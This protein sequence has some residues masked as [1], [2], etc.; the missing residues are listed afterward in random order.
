MDDVTLGADAGDTT[1]QGDQDMAR[2]A[3]V[4]KE[5]KTEKAPR[6]ATDTRKA[7]AKK[8]APKGVTSGEVKFPVEAKKGAG[9]TTA[10]VTPISESG[11][12]GRGIS[13]GGTVASMTR[14]LISEGKLDEKA[15]I[16]K[17]QNAFPDAKIASNLVKHYH[18]QMID[19]GLNPPAIKTA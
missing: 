6:A 4:V 14:D 19:R 7:P 16:A 17:V 3:K 11:R 18:K 2:T 13:T 10:T 12:R 1:D 5:T 8:A 9:K 15:I